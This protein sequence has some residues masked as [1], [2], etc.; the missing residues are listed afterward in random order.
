MVLNEAILMLSGRDANALA[1]KQAE[2]AMRLTAVA[3]RARGAGAGLRHVRDQ[4][5]SASVDPRRTLGL[6]DR[7]GRT[8]RRRRGPMAPFQTVVGCRSLD[9]PRAH[10]DRLVP[11][12]RGWIT[13]RDEPAACLPALPAAQPAVEA[14]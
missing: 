14:V 11:R 2:A 8:H 7:A 5:Q 1:R 10:T 4:L 9:Y 13:A 6:S 12:R 3:A